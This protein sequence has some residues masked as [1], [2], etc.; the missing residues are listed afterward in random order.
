M[1]TSNTNFLPGE[2]IRPAEPLGRYLPRLPLGAVTRWL[3][4]NIPPNSWVLDPFGASPHLALEAAQ[5]GYR[6]L[7]ISSN[8]IIRF[9]LENK[10]TP[11]Q[12]EDMQAAVAALSSARRG[13]ERL[14][15]HIRSLYLTRCVQCEEL[16]DAQAFLWERSGNAPYARIYTCPHCG[17]AGEYPTTAEDVQ[18]LNQISP[19]GLYRSRALER[20]AATDDPNRLHAEEA[21]D[22]YLP[23]AI[24][25]IINIINKL[26]SLNL[27]LNQGNHLQALLLAAFDQGNNLWRNPAEPY[28]PRQLSTPP[29][30]IEK[31]IW[32]A[33]EEAIQILTDDR[34]PATPLTFWPAAPPES[35]GICLYEGQMKEFIK[36]VDEAPMGAI[37]S[38]LPR[39]NQAFW[40]LCALWAGWLWGR[41]AIGPFSTVLK[42]RRYDWSWHTAALNSSLRRLEKLL[43]DET[44]FFGLVTEN[45]AGFDA[46]VMIAADMANFKL[47]A[48]ALQKHTGQTQFYWHKVPNDTNHHPDTSQTPLTLIANAAQEIL[49]QRGQPS[50]Y[51]VLQA[52]GLKALS[53]HHILSPIDDSSSKKSTQA[54]NAY[55]DARQW[56]REAL[57]TPHTFL[58][59]Q[60]GKSSIEIGSWWL[61][62]P[63]ETTPPLADRVEMAIVNLL[64]EQQILEQ[65]QVEEHLYRQFSG[66][67]TPDLPLIE[68]VLASYAKQQPDGRWQLR[69]QDLSQNR[70]E[71]IGNLRQ[72]LLEAGARLG[73]P[74]QPGSIK[75][76]KPLVWEQA[77]NG[78]P[79]YFY[80]VAS[81]V[82]GKIVRHPTHPP[83][84]G[85]IVLPGS[86][87]KLLLFKREKNPY[88]ASLLD[89]GWRIVKFRT[90]RS[91]T[92]SEH[93]SAET[94]AS[95]FALD[96]LSSDDAQLPLF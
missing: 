40:T 39:P 70:R 16:V 20:V 50:S 79:L 60:G 71:D 28:R 95:F 5:A 32:L 14:E 73:F 9:I 34:T 72:V 57:S 49:T 42:R 25:A 19:A 78:T 80:L 12:P 1:T 17:D 89:T 7:V 90:A 96:P 45:E 66:L 69:E 55:T 43:P 53:D 38:A 6:V 62:Q 44:P 87:A 24:Y 56:M 59:Y 13:D 30:F 8:P 23:R 85:L 31:N 58:R 74:V 88:L 93:F 82:L 35:G 46:A 27:N 84:Q 4:E 64:Q 15:V 81:T 61:Q 83:E 94:L 68:A 92:D 41:E 18:R 86:R 36:T 33:I 91:L 54:A 48:A 65:R 3:E 76:G 2:A 26:D 63:P 47:Q 67:Q 10:A 11:P 21:L 75:E 77:Q 51:L 37:V 22:V 52:A 29:H